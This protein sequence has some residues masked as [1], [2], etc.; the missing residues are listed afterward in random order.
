LTR[1]KD[2]GNI[3]LT[4]NYTQAEQLLKSFNKTVYILESRSRVNGKDQETNFQSTLYDLLVEL[5]SIWDSRTLNALPTTLEEAGIALEHDIGEIYQ[6]NAT[7]RIEFLQAKG[8][9]ADHI[10]WGYS[11]LPGSGRG[12]FAKRDLREGTI[13]TG[14]PLHHIPQKGTLIDMYDH[15]MDKDEEESQQN[16]IARQPIVNYCFGH[17]DSSILLFPYGVGVNYI[18][19]QKD[20]NV[21]IQWA[22][23]GSLNQDDSLLRMDPIQLENQTTSRLAFE[24]I[25]TRDIYTG[26]EMFLN[27]GDD[28]EKAWEAHQQSWKE[29]V[30]DEKEVYSNA[31]EYNKRHANARLKTSLEVLADP[32]PTNLQIRCHVHLVD[33]KAET[34]RNSKKTWDWTVKDYGFPCTIL[35]RYDNFSTGVLYTVELTTEPQHRWDNRVIAQMKIDSVPRAAVRFFDVMCSTDMHLQHVFRH[36]IGLPTEMLPDSWRYGPQDFSTFPQDSSA[37]LVDD[38]DINGEL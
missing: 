37:D 5:R 2:F 34:W 12:A 6:Q 24:Y 36:P 19:H 31:H 26:E 20:A 27:Y 23:Q 16:V 10:T 15:N 29:S 35:E 8:R 28:W 4:T 38:K 18:N 7:R 21:K 33:K 11:T 9:C 25:A 14:S 32:Y 22:K 13:I 1:T 17:P 3:P 30:K